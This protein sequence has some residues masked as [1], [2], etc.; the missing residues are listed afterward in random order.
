MPWAPKE[1]QEEWSP[2]E[3]SGW[4]P[5]EVYEPQTST[6]SPVE[7]KPESARNIP[8]ITATTQGGPQLRTTGAGAGELLGKQVKQGISEAA[9]MPGL[10]GPEDVPTGPEITKE[11]GLPI[12]ATIPTSAVAKLGAATI[13]YITSPKGAAMTLGAATPAAPVVFAKWAYDM[14]KGGVES[15]VDIKKEVGSMI[16]DAVANRMVALNNIGPIPEGKT[17]PEHIQTLAE[18]AV[19]TAGMIAGG[20]GAAGHA[21][22]KTKALIPQKEI[23]FSPLTTEAVRETTPKTLEIEKPITTEE[24]SA[25]AI[26]STTSV[27]ESEVRTPVGEETPLRQQGE[28]AGTQAVGETP[29]ET[30]PQVEAPAAADVGNAIAPVTYLGFQEGAGPIPGQQLYN[31]TEDVTGFKKGSTVARSSLEKAGFTIPESEAAKE[32][33]PSVNAPKEEPSAAAGTELTPVSEGTKPAAAPVVQEAQP[34][35]MGGA[36]PSEFE[37]SPRLATSTKNDVVD[38][39]R[40]KRGLPPAIQ[41]ARRSF[42]ETWDRAM[43]HIDHDPNYPDR[44]ISELE[45]S[46]R[47]VNDLEDA[48]LLHRQIDLQNEYGK[49]TRDL[50]QAYDDNRLDA[51]GNEQAR[52]Q[53][54]SDQLFRL[55]EINKKVGTATGRGLAARKMMPYE[56]FTLAKMEVEKRMAKGGEKLTPEEQAEVVR[57]NKKIEE[58][59]QAFDDYVSKTDARESERAIQDA[60]AKVESESKKEQPGYHPRV[61][62]AAEKFA[63]YMDGKA[64]QALERIRSKRAQPGATS[65]L[66]P[67][68]IDD[69]AIIGAAKLTRGIVE[70]AK[71][72]DAMIKD[73]GDW[74]KPHLDDI[75]KSAEA[76]FESESSTFDKKLGKAIGERVRKSVKGMDAKEK[77]TDATS[78]IKERVDEGKQ[79]EISPLVQK[80]ARAFVESGIK[81]RDKLIDAV[82]AELQTIIP[83]ITRRQTM[84]SISGYGD[85]K[86][87]TKDEISKQLRD[88]KGQMQQ[89][90]KL[91]DMQSGQ[92]P[93]K[94][95]LERRIPSPEESR[96][97]KLVN[98]AKNQFQIPIDDPNTQL[99]SSL[100]TLKTRLKNRTTELEGMLSRKEFVKTPKRTVQMDAE[101]NRLHFE[102]SKA[103]AAWHEAMMKDRLA[104]RSIP[105]KVIAGVG[106]TLNTARAVMTSADFSAVLRQGG[107]IAFAHPIRAA[108]SFPAMFKAFRSEAGQHAVNEQ[109]MA[110]ENYPLYKQSGLYLSEHGHKLSQMEEAYMSRWA[111]KIPLVAGSQRAYV[112]FLNKLRADSFDAMANSLARNKEL[113]PVESKAIANFINVATGR[114]NLGMKENALVGM[115]TIFFAPRYVASRFQLLAGQPL[116]QGSARTRMLVAKE[117][118]RFLAGAALV[119]GLASL[120]GAQIETDR[121][122]ADF[123]KLRYGNTRIDPMAGLLQNTV[124]LSRLQTGETKTAKGKIV[125]IR[126]PKVP[127]GGATIPDVVSRFLRSKLSPAIGTGLNLLAQKD[128]VGQPVTLTS[129]A[130]NL[131][132]P[133]SMQDIRKTMIEQGVPRG[134]A[135]GVLSIFGMG[136][137]SYDDK[138]K[139]TLV[140]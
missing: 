34:V 138:K 128:V 54:L 111:D 93:L 119:Y 89:V 79:S 113:T 75:R 127:Y 37:Q 3:V 44:L 43:A 140:P 108:K 29:I 116:Y 86:Q 4:K 122:S 9:E 104:R 46:P 77:Q 97:I 121:R 57:L 87:L 47:A 33:T 136:L 95:G 73:V 38:Q 1:V 105:Q 21:V 50:A 61:L 88:L 28:V 120:D 20:I 66:D 81:D 102:M 22:G 80:L 130:E 13:G 58:T 31:L 42:G 41:P 118:G 52:V 5:P 6:A 24:P 103:K 53:A 115:N 99:K 109:I 26:T 134:S 55:Y 39:E 69:L 35:G 59:Q 133:L 94:T 45:T 27:P 96:L 30:T 11:T 131:F 65:V 40:A 85:F 135:M 124:L 12:L 112:T 19:N 68:M 100:D 125:P 16:Q 117:Y 14:I 2:P 132:I 72:A 114:G 8:S 107:F 83:D 18:D 126:G 23:P 48:T 17:L 137:Q 84:D 123:G 36:V 49:A 25:S 32:K 139:T 63:T 90:A 64:N 51:V 70:G 74:I 67:E 60:L 15:A 10:V 7:L 76:K 62:K 101:A 78:K 106:E 71:W 98:E 82:H 110:R 91:E 92:P 129:T 56:D